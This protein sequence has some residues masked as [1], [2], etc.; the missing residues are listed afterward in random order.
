MNYS[1]RPANRLRRSAYGLIGVTL[2]GALIAS[3]AAV[4]PSAAI[5]QQAAQRVVQ[6]KVEDKADAPIKGAV[7]YLKDG[8]TLAVK[9]YISGG[10]GSYR[11]GQLAQNVD[12]EVWAESPAGGK[13]SAVK[14]ISSFDSKTEINIILK[15]DTGK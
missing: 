3:A 13:K 12:Y 15:I 4:A 5:A 6:G 9:S 10:D 1:V 7:V 14:S 8:R 11:F 2:L